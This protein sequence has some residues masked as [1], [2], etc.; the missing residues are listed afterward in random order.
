MDADRVKE[1]VEAEEKIVNEKATKIKG[2]KDEADKILNEAVPILNG[3]R[4]ALGL[5][6]RQVFS[7]LKYNG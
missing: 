6:N 7:P 1:V 5:L 2:M 4:E 3:A